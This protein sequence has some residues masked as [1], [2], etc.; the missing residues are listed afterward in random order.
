M[1]RPKYVMGIYFICMMVNRIFIQ[2]LADRLEIPFF[3]TSAKNAENVEILFQTIAQ[4]IK[5][6]CVNKSSS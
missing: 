4:E 2:E 1:K 3:E 6:K 5:Q